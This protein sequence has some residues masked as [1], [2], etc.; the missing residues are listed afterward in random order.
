MTVVLFGGFTLPLLNLLKIEKGLE[1]EE[2]NIKQGPAS[3]EKVAAM[4]GWKKIDN[5]YLK[6][7]FCRSPETHCTR[8]HVT[9][10]RRGAR[11]HTHTHK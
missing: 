11:T 5:A 3:V 7:L 4:T 8:Q 9:P 10:H 1:P 2:K 6:P